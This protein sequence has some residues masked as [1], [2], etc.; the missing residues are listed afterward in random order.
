MSTHSKNDKKIRVL[1]VTSMPWREDNNIGN[2]YSNLFGDL[3]NVE[4][5]H[6]YCRSGL[7]QN[8]IVKNYFQITEQALVKNLIKPSYKTGKAFYFDG[9]NKTTDDNNNSVLYNKMR[10]LRWQIFFIARD[11]IWH[12]GRWKSKELD[13]FVDEFNPDLIF[14]T[15]T[16]MPNIN[17]LMVY[18]KKRLN[19]PM[20]TYSWD[21]VYSLKQFSLSPFYWIRKL[22][23]RPAIRKCVNQCEF[24]YTITENMQQEYSSYFNKE[25]KL[26]YKGYNFSGTANV[27]KK[28]KSPIKLVFMGNIG[29]G[30]WKTL[31]K[32][33][34]ALERLNSRTSNLAEL[35]I[36]T[37]S[38]KSTKMVKLL[39]RKNVS[40]LMEAVPTEEVMAVQKSA[41][42]LVHVEPTKLSERLFYRL[43]FSTKIV[44]YFY[45]SRCILGI[46]GKT[47]TLDYLKNKDAGIVVYN[48]KELE[49]TLFDLFKNSKKISEYAEKAWN[50]GVKNHQRKDINELLLNSFENLL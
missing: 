41:D 33:A 21:D 6:I 22:Y 29:A 18:L 35:Y 19:K 20:I 11:L 43:S 47:A 14:G 48:L 25:C 7:P 37:L 13:Q 12:I 44:D 17:R 8:N 31:V 32:L 15:L 3:D 4:F 30:R 40:Y 2:S 39:S 26:L 23:Q 34:D 36:Y 24:M 27:P 9:S 50:C 49:K 42:I 1:L 45:N 46:G 28:I 16:Y 38:P 10:I 5:A